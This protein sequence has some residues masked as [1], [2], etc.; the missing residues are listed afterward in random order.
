M[1]RKRTLVKKMTYLKLV[2]I[3]INS[4]SYSIKTELINGGTIFKQNHSS[5]VILIFYKPLIFNS[6]CSALLAWTMLNKGVN[7]NQEP[8]MEN[9]KSRLKEIDFL[10]I[11]LSALTLILLAFY[12]S[13]VFACFI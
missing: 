7:L 13:Q 1:F 10:L 2:D 6:L 9:V 8:V 11:I 5:Q 4:N 12:V 3:S